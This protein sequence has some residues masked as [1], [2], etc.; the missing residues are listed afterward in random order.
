LND[1]LLDTAFNKFRSRYAIMGGYMGKEILSGK[2][3]RPWKNQ[4]QLARVLSRIWFTCEKPKLPFDV[5]YITRQ[6]DMSPK[7]LDVYFRLRDDFALTLGENSISA[8][9]TITRLVRLL[10]VCSGYVKSDIMPGQKEGQE[11]PLDDGRMLLLSEI[12]Q[13][14]DPCEKIAVFVSKFT[15]DLNSIKAACE[16]AE[17]PYFEISGRASQA[18][19]WEKEPGGVIGVHIESGGEGLDLTASRYGIMYSHQHSPGPRDQAECRITRYPESRE[20]ETRYIID[21]VSNTSVELS[22]VDSLQRRKDVIQ[23]LYTAMRSGA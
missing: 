7:A 20:K 19:Q 16:I 23:S 9:I 4:D 2:N 21:L 17:R 11:I 18:A 14:I 13:E 12:L 1:L 5:Q 15:Y 3:G 8:P 10:Q 6:Y 22:M